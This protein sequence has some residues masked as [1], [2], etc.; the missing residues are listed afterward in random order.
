MTAL[1]TL[2]LALWTVLAFR[3]A[4]KMRAAR[5][6]RSPRTERIAILSVPSE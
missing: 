1:L 3:V 4:R 2:A 5:T 6:D